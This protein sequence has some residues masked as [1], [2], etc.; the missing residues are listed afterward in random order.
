MFEA[1]GRNL[2]FK[3][4]NG[5]A[6][7]EDIMFLCLHKYVFLKDSLYQYDQAH[8]GQCEV[9]LQYFVGSPNIQ[10]F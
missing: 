1:D 3:F 6:S 2:R 7:E 8:S 5:T 10:Q 4:V 9:D